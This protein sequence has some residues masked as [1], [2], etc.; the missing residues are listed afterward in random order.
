MSRKSELGKAMA[1]ML[2]RQDGCRELMPEVI[3]RQHELFGKR[4]FARPSLVASDYTVA[5]GYIKP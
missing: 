2:K 3:W 4:Q 1:Y 5:M